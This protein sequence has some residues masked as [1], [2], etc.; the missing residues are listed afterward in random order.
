MKKYRKIK[1]L[2]NAVV[3]FACIESLRQAEY[4][5]AIFFIC[6]FFEHIMDDNDQDDPP[7]PLSDQ[8]ACE[9]YRVGCNAPYCRSNGCAAFKGGV[10]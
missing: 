9:Q 6:S 4:L 2:L 5:W 10:A 3:L 1:K 7:P 8:F